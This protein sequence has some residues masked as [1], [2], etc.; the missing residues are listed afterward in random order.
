MVAL[1]VRYYSHNESSTIMTE[2]GDG[3]L[4]QGGRN[5]VITHNVQEGTKEQVLAS[6]ADVEDGELLR[7]RIESA[8]QVVI[9]GQPLLLMP[10][11]E[12]PG[13]PLGKFLKMAA[14]DFEDRY[15][16]LTHALKDYSTKLSRLSEEPITDLGDLIKRRRQRGQNDPPSRG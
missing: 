8:E 1:G 5:P 14:G 15:P 3:V 13:M 9:N 12:Q 16:G 10:I 2:H 11:P 7:G 6:L 4:I